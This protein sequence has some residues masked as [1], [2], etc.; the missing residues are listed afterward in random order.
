MTNCVN[1][2]DQSESDPSYTKINCTRKQQATL[3]SQLGIPR[4]EVRQS[5]SQLLCLLFKTHLYLL[6]LVRGLN[7]K[8]PKH[9]TVL[10]ARTKYRRTVFDKLDTQRG[11]MTTIVPSFGM[12]QMTF[13]AWPIRTRQM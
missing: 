8:I 5:S 10:A 2:A 4:R 6:E 11:T 9:S 13:T 3:S 1:F 12:R 7:S